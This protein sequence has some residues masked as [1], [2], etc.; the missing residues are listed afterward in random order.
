M[1]GCSGKWR[2]TRKPGPCELTGPVARQPVRPR[3]PPGVGTPLR[4]DGR[5]GQRH[6]SSH[7]V[8]DWK[9][10][11]GRER[12]KGK[13][14]LACSQSPHDETVVAR[15]AQ[16]ETI[17]PLTLKTRPATGMER[18][19]E[20]TRW[21]R[22][23]WPSPAICPKETTGH[24]REKK[25]ETKGRRHPSNHTGNNQSRGVEKRGELAGPPHR[26]QNDPLPLATDSVGVQ[27][28]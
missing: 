6:P 15:C 9:E 26:T 21:T 14:R 1:N 11:K 17:L 2:G 7:D 16:F 12:I 28:G 18:E 24:Q 23:V 19:G 25:K 3:T 5:P 8:P 22:A 4:A 13:E 27:R 20:G 10:T